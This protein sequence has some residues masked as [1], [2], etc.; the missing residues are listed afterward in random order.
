MAIWHGAAACVSGAETPSASAAAPIYARATNEFAAAIFLKPAGTTNSDLPYQ[1]APLILQEVP[2]DTPHPRPPPRS[3]SRPS[4]AEHDNEQEDAECRDIPAPLLPA[5]QAA[6]PLPPPEALP[7]VFYS[8][9]SVELNRHPHAR[10]AYAWCYPSGAP[11]VKALAL[12]TQGVRLTLNSHGQPVL[13]EVLADTSGLRLIFVSRS[14]EDAAAAEF[15]SPL[16]GRRYAIERSLQQTPGVVVPR[17][18][19]DGPTAM[20]PILHL[21]QGT[22]D[23]STLICRCMPAQAKRLLGTRVFDLVPL[24]GAVVDACLRAAGTNLNAPPA[25]WGAE[26]RPQDRLDRCLRLP[27]GF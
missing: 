15:G 19:E 5:Q 2:G 27:S 12:P 4:K 25:L 22:R 21:S 9:D 10:F 14:L 24:N 17:V 26:D 1:L 13:W 18:I 16:P 23:V 11:G 6:P 7:T 3:R 8:A 20:G